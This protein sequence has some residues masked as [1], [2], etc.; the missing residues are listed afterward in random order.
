MR[1]NIND[2]EVE[3]L[4]TLLQKR[5]K[6]NKLLNKIGFSIEKMIQDRTEK[7]ES[8][9]GTSFQPYSQQYAQK[10]AQHGLPTSP[11]DLKWNQ[12]SGMMSS[13]DH[14]LSRDSQR[15]GVYIRGSRNRRI[16]RYH[17]IKGAGKSKVI[18]RFMG[19]TRKEEERL[20]DFYEDG[21]NDIVKKVQGIGVK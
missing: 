14:K 10:R 21:L 13:L 18:R 8:V 6:D 16:A 9:D 2:E 7:G 5:I 15:L 4:L 11:V 19:I 20:V 12:H 3:E 1:A 17:N